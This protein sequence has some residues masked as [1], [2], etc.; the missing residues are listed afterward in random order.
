M[1]EIEG[2]GSMSAMLLIISI[3]AIGAIMAVKNKMSNRKQTRKVTETEGTEIPESEPEPKK[4][5][6]IDSLIGDL[7]KDLGKN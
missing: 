3:I 5:T 1:T 2:V 4:N 6:D 7:E